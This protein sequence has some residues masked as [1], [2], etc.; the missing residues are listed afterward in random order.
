M[1]SVLT[2]QEATQTGPGACGRFPGRGIAADG[3]ACGARHV[4]RQHNDA[5]TDQFYAYNVN[6]KTA[7]GRDF[8]PHEPLQNGTFN[9]SRTSWRTFWGSLRLR[10][11]LRRT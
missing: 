8:H 11:P 2:A 6:R 9:E 1:S 3:T 7:L 10:R 4:V 5:Y